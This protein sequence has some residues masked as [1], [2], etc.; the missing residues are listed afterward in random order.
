MVASTGIPLHGV[1]DGRRHALER[2]VRRPGERVVRRAPDHPV[3]AVHGG[4][5]DARARWGRRRP[6]AASCH[7]RWTGRCGPGGRCTC[8]TRPAA[9]GSDRCRRAARP[10]S[11]PPPARRRR[12][13][14][15]RSRGRPRRRRA[16]ASPRRRH[17]G[18]RRCFPPA[19]RRSRAG[20]G[21]PARPGP[22]RRRPSPAGAATAGGY[23]EHDRARQHDR[24]AEHREQGGGQARRTGRCA[25]PSPTNPASI[26]DS[27]GGPAADRGRRSAGAWSSS[28]PTEDRLVGHPRQHRR[29]RPPDV[30]PSERGTAGHQQAEQHH[31]DHDRRDDGPSPRRGSGG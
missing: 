20:R 7:R 8:G 25:K 19:R 11:G 28:P 27:H 23:V 13:R 31:A 30:S 5:P 2:V 17:R 12:R 1:V 15:G 10:S 3:V 29:V 18:G 24:H 14:C 4:E 22:G 26:P 21:S 9:R 6:G 16:P